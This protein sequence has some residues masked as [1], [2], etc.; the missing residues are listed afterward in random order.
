[1]WNMENSRNIGYDTGYF[2]DRTPEPME[3]ENDKPNI[4]ERYADAMFDLKYHERELEKAK[5]SGDEKRIREETWWI[6]SFLEIV[7]DIEEEAYDRGIEL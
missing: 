7:S 5:A 4:Y 2:F 3:Y 6:N 1:M